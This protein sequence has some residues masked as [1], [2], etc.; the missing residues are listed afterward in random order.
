M[1]SHRLREHVKQ[2][3]ATNSISHPHPEKKIRETKEHQFTC[4]S[5]KRMVMK[6]YE[7][8]EQAKD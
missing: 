6:S 2:C 3:F 1:V 5:D 8:M 7:A 4:Q